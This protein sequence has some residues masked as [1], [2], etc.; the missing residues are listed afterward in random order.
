MIACIGSDHLV[1]IQSISRGGI[2]FDLSGH[3]D[4]VLSITTTLKDG[5]IASVGA[6]NVIRVQ[7][8]TKESGECIMVLVGHATH[9]HFV[10]QYTNG[11]LISR[12]DASVYEFG[13]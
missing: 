3:V 9:M 5:C 1:K 7:H 4:I 12:G 8:I 6:G 11:M 13:I 10:R 2:L